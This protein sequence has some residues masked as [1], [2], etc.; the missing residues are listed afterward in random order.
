MIIIFFFIEVLVVSLDF[1][2]D[3]LFLLSI[4]DNF[5]VI[6]DCILKYSICGFIV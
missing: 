6:F 1:V 3:M 5:L 2:V 4:K